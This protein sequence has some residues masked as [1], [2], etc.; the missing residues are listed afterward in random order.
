MLLTHLQ[1]RLCRLYEVPTKYDVN[2]FLITDPIL[3]DAITPPGHRANDERLLASQS[4]EQLN[5]SLY[6]EN[7]LLS[8]V[9]ADKPL[10]LLQDGNIDAP[11]VALEGFSYFRR[12]RWNASF[13]KPITLLE[14]QAAMDKYVVALTLLRIQNSSVTS[15]TVHHKLFDNV[16]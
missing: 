13:D 2:D 3:A 15:R 6:L 10:K 16:R 8:L 14:L 12:L 9:V 11:M 5:I 1:K 7:R 4:S